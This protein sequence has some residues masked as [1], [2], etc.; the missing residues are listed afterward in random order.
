MIYEQI[1]YCTGHFKLFEIAFVNVVMNKIFENGLVLLHEVDFMIF[2][3]KG[4]YN[5]YLTFTFNHI[6][7]KQRILCASKSKVAN[8][9]LLSTR[10]FSIKEVFSQANYY[11]YFFNGLYVNVYYKRKMNINFYI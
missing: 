3:F 9:S 10:F 6:F 1:I 2:L 4:K 11:F 5:R 8:Q 7:L